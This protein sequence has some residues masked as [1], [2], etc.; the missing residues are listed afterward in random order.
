M[1]ATID[2]CDI[3][4]VELTTRE[5]S[6]LRR[7]IAVLVIVLLFSVAELVGASYARSNALYAD[8]LHLC[9]DVF[10]LGLSVY[11]VRVSTRT[12]DD[13]Y[14]YGLRRA[15]P[16]AALVNVFLVFGTVVEITHEAVQRFSDHVAPDTSLMLKLSVAALVI[17]A[18]SAWL[19]HG[20]THAGH[21]HKAPA[22]DNPSAE[23]LLEEGHPAYRAD[24]HDHDHAHH[25][26]DHEHH[27]HHGH[28]HEHHAHHG[29]VHHH[30]HG[31]PHSHHG[32]DLNVRGALLHV[33]GDLLSALVAVATAVL[34]RFGAPSWTDPAAS[35]LIAAVLVVG[36][37]RLGKEALRVLLE[38]VPRGVDLAHLRHDL[39][40][41]PDVSRVRNLHV[42][43]LGGGHLAMSAH[44]CRKPGATVTGNELAQAMRR[45]HVFMH[46]TVQVDES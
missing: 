36:A 26:H 18:F 19:L 22:L 21:A 46:L 30:D 23:S 29:H 28:D 5:R 17:N 41:H 15:E 4:S 8:A 14:T 42:W 11:A 13:V 27:P 31:S 33:M 32:H 9:V 38:G 6:Q 3:P 2:C 20:G 45:H 35:L 34:L 25:G 40:S 24:K 44:V 39:A 16:L 37:W 10:A 43:A 1:S 12:P 7:L